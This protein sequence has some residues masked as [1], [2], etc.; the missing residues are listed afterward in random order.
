[1]DGPESSKT[2]V[3]HSPSL[4]SDEQTPCSFGNIFLSIKTIS[5][6]VLLHYTSN[7]CPKL[8][9]LRILT[10]FSFLYL[11]ALRKLREVAELEE[12]CSTHG[13]QEGL[14]DLE[15]AL[16]GTPVS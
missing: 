13:V 9:F 15:L 4:R 5:F 3:S 11:Q 6:K 8:T 7:L 14:Q 2:L 12:V 16:V 1:M 10:N